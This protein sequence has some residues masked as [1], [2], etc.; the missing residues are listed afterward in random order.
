MSIYRVKQEDSDRISD[1]LNLTKLDVGSYNIGPDM[2]ES[3]NPTPWN[4]GKS[5]PETSQRN[6]ERA[7]AG[8]HP[9][10]SKMFREMRRQM[11][12]E[13]VRLQKHAFQ[14]QEL[15]EKT[16]KRNLDLSSKGLHPAQTPEA[17]EKARER[18]KIKYACPHCSKTGT[19]IVFKRWHFDRCKQAH[20]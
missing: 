13:E 9:A 12:A 3:W 18:G 15:R 2:F 17:R 20:L 10:Q 11:I 1:F 5:C 19:G 14:S 8:N 16:R 7:R 6:V 4:K